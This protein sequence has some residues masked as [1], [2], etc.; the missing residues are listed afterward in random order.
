MGFGAVRGSFAP[1][2]LERPNQS[3]HGPKVRNEM[4]AQRDAQRPSLQKPLGS[5]NPL[6]FGSLGLDLER[7]LP[8][9][10]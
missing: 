9:Y 5:L 1:R 7:T 3:D 2:A 4:T 8:T 10:A 6:G